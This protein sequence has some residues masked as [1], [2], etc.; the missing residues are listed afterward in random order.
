[1]PMPRPAPSAMRPPASAPAPSAAKLGLAINA[2]PR[3]TK[4]IQIAFDMST[5][6]LVKIHALPAPTPLFSSS[7]AVSRESI[8]PRKSV[9]VTDG[10]TDVHHRQQ[11]EDQCL[12]ER[13][14]RSQE[15]EDHRNQHFREI[16][17]DPEEQ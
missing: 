7:V 13:N 16:G 9:V 4:N 6:L 5:T 10:E 11:R 2:I 8:G 1:M 14:E 17:E 3:T 12:H 15:I